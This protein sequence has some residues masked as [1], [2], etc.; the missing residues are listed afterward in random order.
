MVTPVRLQRKRTK[1][2]KLESPNGLPVVCVNRP[3]K[4]GNPFVISKDLS[5]EDALKKYENYLKENPKL[6][7]EIKK[8]LKGKNLACFCRLA[9]ACHAEILITIANE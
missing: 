4:W 9:N 5:R 2:F 3:T 1:G 6:I 7:Q 8:E